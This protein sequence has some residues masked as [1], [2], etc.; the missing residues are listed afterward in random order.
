MVFVSCNVIMNMMNITTTILIRCFINTLCFMRC[1][2]RLVF[3]NIYVNLF[4]MVSNIDANVNLVVS[5]IDARIY[6]AFL[7]IVQCSLRNRET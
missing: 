5:N 7:T 1:T 4:Q 2:L 3:S 6:W